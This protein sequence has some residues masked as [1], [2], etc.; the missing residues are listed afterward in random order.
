MIT[1]IFA[2][3]TSEADLGIGD[4]EGRRKAGVIG[5]MGASRG[6]GVLGTLGEGEELYMRCGG[7]KGDGG[8]IPMR[9]GRGSWDI[10]ERCC[11]CGFG[12][13]RDMGSCI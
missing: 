10:C 5:V 9:R 8:A 13:E 12:W 6:C 7:P 2:N 11:G 1:G 3:F 4:L